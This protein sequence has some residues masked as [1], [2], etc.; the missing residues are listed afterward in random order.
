MEKKVLVHPILTIITLNSYTQYKYKGN[1]MN[2]AFANLTPKGKEREYQF[3]IYKKSD[4]KFFLRSLENSQDGNPL[5]EFPL[6]QED[7]HFVLIDDT[8]F[9]E[10]NNVVSE[11]LLA[12]SLEWIERYSNG[13]DD[14]NEGADVTSKPGYTPDDIIVENKPF[15]LK[16]LCDL[17]KSGDLELAPDFQRNFIWDKTRQ[18]RLIESLLLGLPTPSIYLSQYDDGLLTIVDGLQRITT[19]LRFIDN[20]LTLCNLEYLTECNGYT[21]EGLQDILSPLRLRR[22]G[23][24]QIMCF[25]IDYRSPQALKYDL[26]K[27]LNTGGQPLNNQ[28]IRNCLSRKP[29]QA[30]LK[31]MIENESFITATDSSIRNTRMEAQ[32]LA[33]KFICFYKKYNEQDFTG[34][35]DG[36][37][38]ST[39]NAEVEALNNLLA[40]NADAALEYK[41]IFI[42]TL[43]LAYA[44]FERY[45]FRKVY[46]NYNEDGQRRYQ[47]NK[48]LFLGITV[49]LAKNYEK[50]KQLEHADIDM[51][52]KLAHII[53]TD[54]QFFNA[55]TWSTNSKGNINYVFKSLKK[56]FDTAIHYEK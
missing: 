6:E 44:L 16:Q 53:E 24:T 39:L 42:K 38:D 26:F 14:S 35:Y 23:Q 2:N 46:E 31:G 18:S 32:E 4:E 37:M 15:S 8:V 50:Y 3:A 12:L 33:L 19:I 27:R 1:N 48:S 28:E 11:K 5:Y 55:M 41:D 9:E 29:L 49:T 34:T 36:N 25:V 40:Q 54:T 7:N 20:Q 45:T 21:Y 52:G 51:V 13:M 30:L 56:L 17:V 47:I 10:S 43:N 22:F